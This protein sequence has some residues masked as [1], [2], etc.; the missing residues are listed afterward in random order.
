MAG[1]VMGKADTGPSELS[2]GFPSGGAS[3]VS[4]AVPRRFRRGADLGMCHGPGLCGFEFDMGARG[5][6]GSAQQAV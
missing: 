4:V 2:G 6:C 1:R 3:I 5:A